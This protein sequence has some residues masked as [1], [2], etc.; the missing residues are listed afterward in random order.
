[1]PAT[2]INPDDQVLSQWQALASIELLPPPWLEDTLR[3]VPTLAA[4]IAGLQASQQDPFVVGINGAQGTGK[5]TLA[6]TIAIMLENQF[7]LKTTVLSLDDF[8]LSHH[9]RQQLGDNVH[10]LLITRGVPGT[11]DIPQALATLQQLRSTTG[12]VALPGF[13][14]ASDDC[15]APANRQHTQA[16]RDVIILEGWCVGVPPQASDALAEPVNSLE[17]EEDA[18][19]RWRR[20]V[21]NCLA[22]DY[23][24]LFACLDYLV[25]LKAP[26][27]ECVL[28]WRSLQEAKLAAKRAA[29][30]TAGTGIMT[31]DAIMRFIQHYERLTRHAF[32]A[33]PGQADVV[34]HLDTD[35]RIC[36]S[37]Y[38]A[39]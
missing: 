29:E 19:G 23:Q 18:D 8:Y 1:M 16:P 24:D 2:T 3:Y 5:S 10:P 26:S 13:D 9:A 6:R 17:A 15:V 31:P 11:H 25:M 21:N 20:H 14:K 35:H 30:N 12:D 33:L 22:S 4:K 36:G 32:S 37:T 39:H 38:K 28:E 7:H 27:F 34:L